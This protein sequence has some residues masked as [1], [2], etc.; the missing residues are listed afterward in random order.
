MLCGED[1]FSEFPHSRLEVSTEPL[2]R[3]QSGLLFDA[4]VF[5]Q[6]YPEQEPFACLKVR[7]ILR[8]WV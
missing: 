6:G 8:Y 3:L 1:K 5:I 7:R 4:T 2:Q